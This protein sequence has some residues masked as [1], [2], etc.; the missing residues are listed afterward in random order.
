LAR[1]RVGAV[2]FLEKSLRFQHTGVVS[3]AIKSVVCDTVLVYVVSNI[4]IVE[5]N[6]VAG[7]RV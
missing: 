7:G 1:V 4:P 6:S 5:R 3:H 2:S